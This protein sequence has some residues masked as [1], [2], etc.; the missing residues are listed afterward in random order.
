MAFDI[1][2]SGFNSHESDKLNVLLGKRVKI[3]LFSGKT[4]IGVLGKNKCGDR[5]SV[6][7]PYGEYTFY[8]THVKKVEADNGGN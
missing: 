2:R 5:Y 7:T 3:T 1:R 8:K 4:V 6:A